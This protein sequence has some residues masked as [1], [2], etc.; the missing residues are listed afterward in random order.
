M[1]RYDLAPRRN[2]GVPPIGGLAIYRS[3]SRLARTQLRLYELEQY[4]EMAVETVVEMREGA[5]EETDHL[6]DFARASTNGDAAKAVKN[7]L[8]V[9]DG[10]RDVRRVL[11][12]AARE[13]F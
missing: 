5:I 7:A 9:E 10:I 13:V 6:I 11:N 12:R 8:L 3:R 1:G 4:A 2:G